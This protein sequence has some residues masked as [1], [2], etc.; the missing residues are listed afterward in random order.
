MALQAYRNLL[1]ASRLTFAGDERLLTN[2]RQ[3]IRAGFR[4]KAGLAPSDPA[5]APAVQQAE[6]IAEMLRT[7]VVQGR[8]EGDGRFMETLYNADWLGVVQSYGYMS[9][10]SGATMIRLRRRMG[11][12]SRLG[13]GAAQVETLVAI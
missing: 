7:N 6:Q 3:S 5:V 1:R 9:I 10:P 13:P 2:A 11:K 8:D 12:L 4:E